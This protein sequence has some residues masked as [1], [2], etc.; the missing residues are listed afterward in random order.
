MCSALVSVHGLKNKLYSCVTRLV[1]LVRVFWISVQVF[2]VALYT[3]AV[4]E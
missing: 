3:P 2:R 4:T 1:R